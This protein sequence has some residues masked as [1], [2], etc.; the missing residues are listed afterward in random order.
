MN[1]REWWAKVR[2]QHKSNKDK[3]GDLQ[4]RN[5]DHWT[6]LPSLEC[7]YVHVHLHM[8]ACISVYMWDKCTTFNMVSLI[9]KYPAVQ[10]NTHRNIPLFQRGENYRYGC[11]RLTTNSQLMVH[12][13]SLALA[14]LSCTI[15]TC[16]ET[17]QPGH[18]IIAGMIIDRFS[19]KRTVLTIKT[20]RNTL[21]K[22][23]MEM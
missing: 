2:F 17:G 5:H 19:K 13:H 20:A 16:P 7:M 1:Q 9:S 12:W 22:S 6:S 11:V 3:V 14:V 10:R 23:N 21:Q 4:A 15:S 8:H 18:R